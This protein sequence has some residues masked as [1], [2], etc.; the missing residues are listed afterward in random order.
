ML[1]VSKAIEL[2]KDKKKGDSSV[3]RFLIQIFIQWTLLRNGLPVQKNQELLKKKTCSALF[4]TTTIER[5]VASS[6]KTRRLA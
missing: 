6:S 4:F 3:F 1:V 2:I 5:S